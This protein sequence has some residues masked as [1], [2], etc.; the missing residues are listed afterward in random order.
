[1]IGEAAVREVPGAR[2]RT[3]VG[4]RRPGAKGS[5]VRLV[6][7]PDGSAA[8]DHPP[9]LGGRGAWV[10]AT[11][12][13]FA[14]AFEK[15]ALARAF[16]AP[17]SGS[18]ADVRGDLHRRLED[19]IAGMIAG[20]RGGRRIA[21]GTE[22]VREVLAAGGA[23]LVLFASD[24]RGG[25]PVLE[26]AAGRTDVRTAVLLDK[27]RIG[28]AVGKDEVGVLAVLDV[29]LAAAIDREVRLLES[30]HAEPAEPTEATR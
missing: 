26:A 9:R 11:L 18:A 13:C 14:R 4:C 22:A 21:V 25:R 12:A 10:H 7:A 20:G 15:G 29:L 30:I 1:M 8:V 23:N 28:R 6:R 17:V 19:R 24:A 3:C 2:E 16:G 27:A 5:L